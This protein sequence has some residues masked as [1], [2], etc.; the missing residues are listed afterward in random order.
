MYQFL[1]W[2]TPYGVGSYANFSNDFYG[3]SGLHW[4]LLT[5]FSL[6]EMVSPQT[7]LTW[8]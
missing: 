4:L 5:S 8:M 6:L 7:S 2:E 1:P 3:T